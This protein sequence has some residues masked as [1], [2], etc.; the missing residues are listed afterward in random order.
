MNFNLKFGSCYFACQWKYLWLF[1]A[2]VLLAI[3]SFEGFLLFRSFNFVIRILT[4][5]LIKFEIHQYSIFGKLMKLL[6]DCLKFS[7]IS[8]C[9]AKPKVKT[10]NAVTKIKT[11][12]QQHTKLYLIFYA[13]WTRTKLVKCSIEHP[14]STLHGESIWPNE[15]VGIY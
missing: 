10:N 6:L 7:Y 4:W 13:L 15:L 9:T 1:V 14:A 12:H 11:H 5:E 2:N 8:L 3:R